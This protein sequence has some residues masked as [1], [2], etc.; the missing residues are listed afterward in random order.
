MSAPEFLPCGC[1]E[2]EHCSECAAM[3]EAVAAD[4]RFAWEFD[5]FMDGPTLPEVASWDA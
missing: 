3:T 2:G 5:R 1:P 4:D